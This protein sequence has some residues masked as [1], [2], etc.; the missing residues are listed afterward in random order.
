MV[1]LR[2]RA[3][4]RIAALAGA[5]G[6]LLALPAAPPLVAQNEG[7]S[8]RPIVVT[9]SRYRFEPARIEVFQNDLVTVE[10]RTSDIP[11]SFTID[12]YRIAKRTSPAHPITFEFRADKTGSFPFY[13]NLQTE[14]GCRQ[15]R[16]ELV[17]K[18]R[19]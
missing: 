10:F 15:M 9:A 14:E 4:A 13:C 1:N 12:G 17:V 16:G 7:P 6:V 2:V 3:S 8:V 18:P 19:K 5:A 11:H